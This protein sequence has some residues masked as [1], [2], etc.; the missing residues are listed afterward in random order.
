MSRQAER[1]PLLTVPEVATRLRVAE[2]TVRRWLRSGRMSGVLF[3]DRSGYRVLESEVE[4]FIAANTR[5]G[6]K[7]GPKPRGEAP[8]ADAA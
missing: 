2:E 8:K 1:D 4:R 3:S 6:N 7:P 5:T